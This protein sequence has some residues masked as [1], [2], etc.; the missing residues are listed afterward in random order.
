MTK[1][2][3]GAGGGEGSGSGAGPR[4]RG[5]LYD[6]VAILSVGWLRRA[7]KR[8]AQAHVRPQARTKAERALA[9]VPQ[10][11][12][13]AAEPEWETPPRMPE[14]IEWRKVVALAVVTLGVYT[15]GVM[16]A[17]LEWRVAQAAQNAHPSVPA[18]IGERRINLLI[19]PMFEVETEAYQQRDREAA[20]LD[21]YGWT[22]RDAGLIHIP[23]LR[24]MDDL[25][26]DE[27]AGAPTRNPP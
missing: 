8:A 15:I 6:L 22:D 20:R 26:T 5:W 17:Y 23:I 13:G 11:R 2:G 12:E 9:V 25:L 27:D 18:R 16:F 21:S 14:G 3:G 24:A 19:Q 4:R 10:M 1:S 7:A